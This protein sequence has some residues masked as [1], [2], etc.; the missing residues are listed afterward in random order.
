MFGEIERSGNLL[1]VTELLS[2]EG[3]IYTHS[4]GHN[5]TTIYLAFQYC[6]YQRFCCCIFGGFSAE[7]LKLNHLRTG[8]SLV[9][10]EESVCA[11]QYLVKVFY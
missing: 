6:S 11:I 5:P 2:S 9:E 8:S 4:L 7:D 3:R 10:C 1:V